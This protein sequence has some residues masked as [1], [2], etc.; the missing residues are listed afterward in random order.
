MR[1]GEAIAAGGLGRVAAGI[2]AAWVCAAGTA[3]ALADPPFVGV[4]AGAPVSGGS[5]LFTNALAEDIAASGCRFVRINFIGGA[6]GWDAT[7][8]GQ[9]DQ[10]VASA[11]NHDL[12]ILGIFSNETVSG[13]SQA[14]WNQNYNTTGLNAYTT[15]YAQTCALLIDR[16]KNDI[17]LFELW[18]EPSCWAVDP[19]TNPLN[20]GCSYIWPRIFANLMA[21]TY[22]ACAAQG[23]T[24]FFEDHGIALVS[25]GLF[26][27]DIAG[28]NPASA[29]AYAHDVYNQTDI[30]NAFATDPLN[31]SGRTY[32]WHYFGYHFYLNGG[33]AVSTAELDA[34]FNRNVGGHVND[35]IHQEQMNHGD[36]A[37]IIVTEFGW[38]TEGVGEELKA[39]N[40]T[41]SFN[42]MRT[43]SAIV[44]AMW[45]QYN[46]CDPNGDWGLT[47]GIGNYEP[48]WY[49]LA[50]QAGVFSPPV[51]DFSADPTSGDAPLQVQFTELATGA[52]TAYDWDF[53]DG[54]T[55][56]LASPVHNYASAGTYTVSLTVSGPGGADTETKT[57][58]INVTIPVGA[59]D[60]DTNG[61]VDLRDFAWFTR[62]F[63]GA[64]N[65]SPPAGCAG[66]AGGTVA[67]VVTYGLA[68]SLGELGVSIAMDDAL[69]GLIGTLE[70]GGFHD[71]V[72][73]G[74]AGGLADLT[75]GAP[76]INLEAVLADFS[77]P[78]LQ[79]VYT[80][81]PPVSIQA[82]RVIAANSDGR[83][84][85]NYDVAYSVPGDPGFNTLLT[86]VTTGPFGQSNNGSI[87]ASYTQIAGTAFGPVATD[88]D[89]L[90]FT[91]FCVSQT[92]GEFRDPYDAFE[93]GDV[94]GLGQA[95]QATIVKEIDVIAFNGE[96]TPNVA[97]LDSDGDADLDDLELLVAVLV[98]PNP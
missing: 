56:G 67:P 79:V 93:P 1:T 62:C 87:G 8:L 73:G 42:W 94:D 46:C 52:I 80:L 86:G 85:Q 50:D 64:G 29:T 12:Q 22:K 31:P 37:P 20:P 23:G 3:V 16:Y 47:Q 59:G 19:N 5:I 77:R 25:G 39:D 60:L 13:Y 9:Y 98:G 6:S 10:I 78:S 74:V 28:T 33:S 49:A 36:S 66:G 90:R 43:Q 21:E 96:F 82:I 75:D 44:A 57:D 32:P 34:Y 24:T 72:P 81:S 97:D 69:A 55:S 92:T 54:N 4:N 45:Y 14:D 65:Q 48:A 53:G 91:F 2:F 89:A 84:F 7:R 63:T 61:T 17:K 95:F 68:E 83:V 15:A 88:V 40:L 18:N 35:G 41:D 26:A 27:H 70:A 71:A 58:Y 11:R 30:W 76:G 51:A 38:T